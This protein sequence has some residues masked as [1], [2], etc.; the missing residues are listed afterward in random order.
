MYCFHLQGGEIRQGGKE[1]EVRGVFSLHFKPEVVAVISSET[2]VNFDIT[3]RRQISGDNSFQSM[4][5]KPQISSYL[6]SSS[7]VRDVFSETNKAIFQG[8]LIFHTYQQHIS[9]IRT[10]LFICIVSSTYIHTYQLLRNSI[11]FSIS[12][13]AICVTQLVVKVKF[14]LQ[15]YYW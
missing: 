2:L 6:C 4:L 9:L 1:E 14:S 11:L 15:P 10:M 7:K 3:T 12:L 13:S 5:R 8:I